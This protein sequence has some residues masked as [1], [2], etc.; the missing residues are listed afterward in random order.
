M[1]ALVATRSA[2]AR[3]FM[4]P[5]W[6]VVDG[7]RLFIATGMESWTS[8]NIDGRPEL[9][10]LFSGEGSGRT[11]RILRLRG[12]ATV[13]RG[14]PPW[15]ILLRIGAKYYTSPRALRAELANIRKW[16]FRTRYCGQAKGD[17]GHLRIVPTTAEFLSRP[18]RVG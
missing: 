3:P 11:D 10:L 12:T 8:R 16:R 2:N 5:L 4:T 18:D 14:L 9:V 15:R 13:R 1:V 7:G 6:F 17:P